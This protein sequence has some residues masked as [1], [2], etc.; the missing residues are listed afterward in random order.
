MSELNKDDLGDLMRAKGA[1]HKWILLRVRGENVRDAFGRPIGLMRH[2]VQHK[3]FLELGAWAVARGSLRLASAPGKRQHQTK[4]R[5]VANAG[6]AGRRP[7]RTR[8]GGK[9]TRLRHGKGLSARK[10][11]LRMGK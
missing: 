9:N 3:H 10:R 8:V 5:T 11:G 2:V 7:R 4:E 1:T 6:P